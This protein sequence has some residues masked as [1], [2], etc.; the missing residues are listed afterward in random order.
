MG[1]FGRFLLDCFAYIWPFRIVREWERGGFLV[2]GRW[3]KEVGPGCY[4]V[5]P[6][7]MDVHDI[8][9]AEAICGTPRLDITLKD[10][11]TLSFSASATVKVTDVT[12]A[13]TG[14]EE[15][16]ETIRELLA[17]VLAE[18]LADVD[19]DR[20]APDKRGRLLTDLRRWV[21]AEAEPYGVEVRNVRF[22][23]FLQNAKAH[24]LI[25]DQTSPVEW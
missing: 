24:R 21:Q 4:F 12:K 17:A 22:T 3:K 23:S 10:R 25:I 19:A 1:D 11:S 13:V 18:K 5:V 2:F 7:F 16:K 6:F 8:S 14:V 9:I 15:Y 20:L